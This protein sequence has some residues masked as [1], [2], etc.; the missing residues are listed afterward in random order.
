MGLR[1][2]NQVDEDGTSFWVF[3]SRNVRSRSSP[4]RNAC[5]ADPS[6][7]T[8]SRTSLRTRWI[9]RCSGSPCTPCVPFLLSRERKLIS[10]CTPVPRRVDPPPLHRT[11]QVQPLIPPHRH[12]RSRVQ[13]HQHGRVHLRRTFLL[14]LSWVLQLTLV[15]AQDRDAKR[16]WA[17]GMAGSGMLGSMGGLGGSIVGGLAQNAF[18]RMFT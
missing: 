1:F 17:T 13:H 5:G 6:C 7:L 10:L 11:P 4:P 14:R 9:Q 12:A 18:G 3:E 15:Y 8:N 16:R 2:W